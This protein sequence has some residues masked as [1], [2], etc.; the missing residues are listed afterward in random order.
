MPDT[1]DTVTVPADLLRS[2][3]TDLLLARL[4]LQD[5][6]A[7]REPFDLVDRLDRHFHAVREILPPLV[8]PTTD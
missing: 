8:P 4:D 3:R 6:G 5:A 1:P 7:S 2:I